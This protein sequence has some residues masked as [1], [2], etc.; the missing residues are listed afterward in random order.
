[1]NASPG[2]APYYLSPVRGE[3]PDPFSAKGRSQQNWW[4]RRD[5]GM[6]SDAGSNIDAET[7]IKIKK[8][9]QNSFS[10]GIEQ[11]RLLDAIE[12]GELIIVRSADAIKI[13]P[14]GC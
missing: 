14:G 3:A 10:W 1:M 9:Y 4:A 8:L 6:P 5:S 13:V 11:G 12:K 7:A 2:E